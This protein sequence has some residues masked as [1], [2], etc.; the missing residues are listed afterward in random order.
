[1]YNA[2][3]RMYYADLQK[4]KIMF[5]NSRRRGLAVRADSGLRVLGVCPV[6]FI[7]KFIQ[8]LFPNLIYT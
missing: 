3:V 2:D 7:V 1:M 5:L 4:Y 8:I 6:P